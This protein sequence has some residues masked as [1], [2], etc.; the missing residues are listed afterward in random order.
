MPAVVAPI[1]DASAA[2]LGVRVRPW[3]DEH[4]P[5]VRAFNAR[6]AARGVHYQFPEPARA[7]GEAAG[8]SPVRHTSYLALDRTGSV[9]GGYIIKLQDYFVGA[10][11][12]RWGSIGCRSR[13][14]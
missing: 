13:R 11:A 7:N 10:N 8:D 9:R 12:G 1:G 4:R 2:H 5:A 14:V 6:L 3:N